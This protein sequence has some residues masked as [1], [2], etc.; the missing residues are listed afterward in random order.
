[1]N[2]EELFEAMA[3]NAMGMLRMAE[4]TNDMEIAIVAH[5]TLMAIAAVQNGD[6]REFGLLLMAFMD[7]A[8]QKQKEKIDKEEMPDSM[9]ELLKNAGITI[10]PN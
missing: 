1:M 6:H 3:H 8:T 10:N 9:V 4:D 2:K 5:A 7:V